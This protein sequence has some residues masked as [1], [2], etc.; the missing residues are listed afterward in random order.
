[1]NQ[2][3]NSQNLIDNDGLDL[4]LIIKKLWKQRILISTIFIFSCIFSVIY[5]LALPDVYKSR[6]ILAPVE[7]TQNS[8]LMQNSA[9]SSLAS[10]TGSNFNTQSN[11]TNEAVQILKSYSFFKDILNEFSMKPALLASTEWDPYEKKLKMD[12]SIFDE[13]KNVWLISEPS[14]QEAFKYWI[15]IFSVSQDIDTGFI[16]MEL[17]HFSP[18][19]TKEWLEKIVFSINERAKMKAIFEAENSI[20]YLK[21]QFQSSELSEVRLIL[22][23]L[24]QEQIKTIM[25]AKS[26]PEYLFNVIDP[27]YASESKSEPKRSV[28][29]I[30]GA[31]LGFILSV[32]IALLR[33]NY[34]NREID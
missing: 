23:G 28:I 21:P 4:N 13:E 31:L 19:L 29:C 14:D 22:A 34:L 10:I 24:I 26:K 27:P 11:E 9:F 12:S 30:I 32:V 8:S 25:L 2:I 1:M 17:K 18:N 33:D 5:A 7:N 20:E 16:A 6:V 15:D 3:I